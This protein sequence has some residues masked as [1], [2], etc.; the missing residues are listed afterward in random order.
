[1]GGAEFVQGIAAHGLD[2]SPR[3]VFIVFSL[4][5]KTLGGLDR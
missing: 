1:M 2:R 3:D 5:A 4:L